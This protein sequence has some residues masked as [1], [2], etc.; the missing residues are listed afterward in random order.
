MD[1]A[2]IPGDSLFGSGGFGAPGKPVEYKDQTE[3]DCYFKKAGDDD[4]LGTAFDNLSH[5]SAVENGT[6]RRRLVPQD[7]A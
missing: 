3:P 6:C 1:D 4:W 2:T 5:N 7:I